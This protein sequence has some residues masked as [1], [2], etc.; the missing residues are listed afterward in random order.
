MQEGRE[1]KNEKKEAGKDTE[2]E[3]FQLTHYHKL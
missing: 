1:N 3:R 2:C